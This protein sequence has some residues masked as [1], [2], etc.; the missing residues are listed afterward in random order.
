MLPRYKLQLEK[1]NKPKDSPS[2][3]RNAVGK[4]RKENIFFPASDPHE[5]KKRKREKFLAVVLALLFIGL[6]FLEVKLTRLS[7]TLPFVNSIF[8]FGILN[9]NL[10]ILGTLFWLIFRNIGKIF[11]EHRSRMLGASLKT[12]LVLAFLS[13]SIIPTLLLFLISSSYINSSFDKWF[14]IKVQ[15]TLQASLDIT[16]H[17]YKNTDRVAQ[18]FAE[19]VS[20]QVSREFETRGFESVDL[21]LYSKPPKWIDEFLDR[22]RDMLALDA[23]EFYWGSLGERIISADSAPLNPDDNRSLWLVDETYP[24]I[25]LDVLDRAFKGE[26]VSTLHHIQN[27]DLF[28]SLIPVTVNDP[29]SPSQRSTIGVIAVNS[30]IPVSLVNKVD[31]ISSVFNDYKDTNP[32]K[33]PI[34]STYFIILIMITLVIIFVAIWIGLY[35]ARELTVPVERL[36]Q[37]AALVGQGKLDFEIEIT[38]QDEISVLIQSFNRMTKDLN[39]NRSRLTQVTEDLEK[40]KLELE[41]VLANIGT[42]VIVLDKNRRI[43]SLNRAAAQLLDL[44]FHTTIG[45]DYH[46]VLNGDREKLTEIIDR[47]F[48]AEP[49]N[50][51]PE[52]TQWNRKVN[53]A[54]RALAGIASPMRDDQQN[55]GVL[56]VVDDLTHLVKAQREVA[57]R[58]V[59]RRIAHEIKNPLTPIKLSAQRL[60]RRLGSLGGKDGDILRE[61]TETI[62][63]NTNELKD[64]VNEFSNFARLPEISPDRNDLNRVIDEVVALYSQAHPAIE[65]LTTLEKKLPQ[66]DFDRDQIKR[67]IIN[68]FNNAVSAITSASE[69]A[70]GKIEIETHFNSKLHICMLTIKDNGPGMQ[71]QVREQVFEPYFSTKDEGTGLG[72]AIAKRIVNDHDGFIRV[73]STPG[74]GTTFLIE[75]PTAQ[76]RRLN[77]PERPGSLDL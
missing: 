20:G 28:R 1:M 61:C 68:L 51:I 37:G 7:S 67:V 74:N 70:T 60:Q 33:Y 12:K 16:N 6:T 40:R 76:K 31:E 19:H 24:P 14:S 62:V 38:G 25:S 63:Q 11:F 8:F 77:L 57:W 49:G 35:I 39:E 5:K 73:Q 34:K 58:E 65:F 13:F 27:G 71:E 21:F 9:I 43:S 3:P 48:N 4:F 29:R 72:L 2:K 46:Q 10:I 36:V 53:S 52:V 66:F 45:K 23:I 56:A 18:H 32:L 75:L 64:L 47:A 59:A 44:D 69:T 54:V 26:T 17:Y 55:W 42:G 15:N 30:Y 41:A 50:S 22:Y